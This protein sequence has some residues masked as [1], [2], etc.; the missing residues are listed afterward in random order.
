MSDKLTVLVS[1]RKNSKY[2]S[3]FLHGYFLRTS[4]GATIECLVMLNEHDTWNQDLVDYYIRT[5][6]MMGIPEEFHPLRFFKEDLKL[7]RAGLHE[8]FNELVKHSR[9]KWL[10]YFCE[11]HYITMPDWDKY[12]MDVIE[13]T[14]RQGDSEGKPFPLNPKYP[15]I[16]VPKFDNCGAMNHVVSRGFIETL[17]GRIG[18][19]GWID[20]YINDLSYAA[21][22]K[23]PGI[24]IRLDDEMFHDFTHDSPS[25]MSDAHLQSEVTP[26][27]KNLPKHGSNEYQEI[28][29]RDAMKLKK[30]IM[31]EGING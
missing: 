10:I 21:L 8:Y 6:N 15:W 1:A 31:E 7:G 12:I 25:P 4:E 20:S 29:D 14:H 16:I 18:N 11:D 30:A 13:G 9:G 26:D 5:Q 17:G 19:H 27:A 22:G 2:L 23:N 28:I 3:K 24:V